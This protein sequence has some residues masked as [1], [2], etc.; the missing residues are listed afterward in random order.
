MSEDF[1]IINQVLAAQ[2]DPNLADHFIKQYMPFIRSETAKF[3]KRIPQEGLDDELSIAMFA[4]YEAMS[5]YDS[6]RGPFLK[7]AAFSIKNRLID[8]YRKEKKHRGLLSL[9]GPA[10]GDEETALLDKIDT[11]KDNVE[12]KA[13]C[14]AAKEEISAF[15]NDLSFFGLS[16]SDVADCCPKQQK[17]LDAC[18]KV[19]EFAKANPE[20]LEQLISSK[21]LPIAQLSAGTGVERK[22]IERHRKYIVAIMLAFTNGFEIIRGHLQQMQKKEV[23]RP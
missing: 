23:Q 11:G 4:F 10:E 1:E 3:I 6:K 17:T 15:A 22:T 14:I 19:L 5:A 7:L 13:L 8:Y 9:E 21:K 20:L 12:E 18:M 16:L 2:N